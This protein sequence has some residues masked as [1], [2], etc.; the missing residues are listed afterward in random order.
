MKVTVAESWTTPAATAA[1]AR[2][3]G[4]TGIRTRTA[5]LSLAPAT[6]KR[7]AAESPG[8]AAKSNRVSRPRPA[9]SVTERAAS[10]VSR[11]A[12]PGVAAETF[13]VGVPPRR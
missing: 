2:V 13:T 7:K 10:P 1:P 12:P 6:S 9:S 3:A 4:R 8:D 5:S 11:T